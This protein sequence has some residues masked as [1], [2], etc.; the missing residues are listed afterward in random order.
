ME[1]GLE[2]PFP[3]GAGHTGRL[4]P[5]PLAFQAGKPN[6]G[7]F[8]R[9]GFPSP[10]GNFCP[11]WTGTS[12][13]FRPNLAWEV[14]LD[15][16]WDFPRIWGFFGDHRDSINCKQQLQDLFFFLGA[17]QLQASL[18]SQQSSWNGIRAPGR[19]KWE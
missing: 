16:H 10:G 5:F 11:S 9:S 19:K 13:S 14:P 18:E 6:S 7:N 1:F 12:S 2:K 3:A 8:S 15:L 17:E 4:P